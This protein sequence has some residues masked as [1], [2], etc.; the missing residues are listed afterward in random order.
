MFSSPKP[1]LLNLM[2]I[3]ILGAAAT[4]SFA[5]ADT[6]KLPAGYY[7]LGQMPTVAQIAGW[8]IDIRPDG[9]GLPKGEGSVEAGEYIYEEKCS[10]CH[11]SFGEG[12]DGYPI[13]AGGEGSLTDMRPQKTVGSYWRFSST[14]WDYINRTMPFNEPESLNADEVYALVAYVLYLNDLVEDD[15]V[16]NHQNLADIHLPNEKNFV[17]DPRPDVFNQRCMSDCKKDEKITIASSAKLKVIPPA[18][19]SHS[20]STFVNQSGE[21]VYRRY[22]ALCHKSG[23]GGAPIVGANGDWLARM[24]VGAPALVQ[25]AIDGFTGSSGMMPPKGGFVNLTDAQVGDAVLYMIEGSH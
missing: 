19:A 1:I 13:L 2:R 25:H 22:C 4:C 11:G 5:L 6:E 14:L 3:F 16:L 24:S 9:I 23:L 18:S 12:V 20:I 15:L 8:D 10:L 7:D 21:Q 17:A